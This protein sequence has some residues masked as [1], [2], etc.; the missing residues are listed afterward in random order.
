MP[1]LRLLE[2]LPWSAPL[3]LGQALCDEPELVSRLA[4]LTPRVHAAAVAAPNWAD[5]DW[6]E[7]HVGVSLW[8]ADWFCLQSALAN[9]RAALLPL[10]AAASSMLGGEVSLLASLPAQPPAG[11]DTQQ[12]QQL[13][14]CWLT[15]IMSTGSCVVFQ[16]ST[17]SGQLYGDSS[18]A[19]LRLLLQ[20]VAASAQ[21]VLRF[22]SAGAAGGPAAESI[23][24]VEASQKYT[25]D[26]ALQFWAESCWVV[27]HNC[28]L[29]SPAGSAEQQHETA[30]TVAG[31]LGMLLQLLC[32]LPRLAEASGEPLSTRFIFKASAE[33]G[34]LAALL[35]LW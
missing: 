28:K 20:A 12:A 1:L 29:C 11:A 3:G 33:A 30:S 26:H 15:A 24:R 14:K 7:R 9:Q 34:A 8:P 31:L 6:S 21:H 23:S 22:V 32:R 2:L 4:R 13:A 27:C 5:A 18:P 25:L 17:A 35:A 10:L 19:R 16:C